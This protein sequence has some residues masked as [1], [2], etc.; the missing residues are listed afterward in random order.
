MDDEAIQ[1]I[2]TAVMA[3]MDARHES[4]RLSATEHDS[5]HRLIQIMIEERQM[6]IDRKVQR[7]ARMERIADKIMGTVLLG[8]VLTVLGL[9]GAG[10]LDWV[11]MHL[12]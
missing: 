3:A 12:K 8:A 4:Q 2:V 7:M 9:I 1:K 5:H 6:L 11:R 10:A